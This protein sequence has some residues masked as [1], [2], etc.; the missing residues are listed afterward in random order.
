VGRGVCYDI[1]PAYPGAECWASRGGLWNVSGTQ[2]STNRPGSMNFA[3]WWDGDLLRE[4][5]D[6][7]A[8]SK[9]NPSAFAFTTLLNGAD[10]NAGSNNGTKATP[11]LSADILG[12]W[13]EEVVWRTADNTELLVFSTTIPT[14]H[15]IPTLMHDA[16]YRVQV[17]GQN[18]GYNQPPH[19]SFYIGEGVTPP[20]QV[21]VNVAQ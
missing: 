15:R 19:T 6:G 8:I 5:L 13:R 14:T 21:S 7:V 9:W 2:I 1:D 11:V 17:A 10:Y 4:A 3:S 20:A 16:Q 18:A 12:D